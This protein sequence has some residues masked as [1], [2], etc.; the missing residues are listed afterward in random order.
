LNFQAFCKGEDNNTHLSN[1]T[2]MQ[3]WNIKNQELWK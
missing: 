3:L 2:K 1:N